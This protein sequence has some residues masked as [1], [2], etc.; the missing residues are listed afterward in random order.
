MLLD[1]SIELIQG[2]HNVAH[3]HCQ[4]DIEAP[5]ISDSVAILDG[6]SPS[7]LRRPSVSTETVVRIHSLGV[8]ME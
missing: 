3:H 6:I 8:W 7:H 4:S 2:T 5:K 1:S